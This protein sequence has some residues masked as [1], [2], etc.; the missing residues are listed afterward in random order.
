MYKC[1]IYIPDLGILGS[2][3]CTTI[4]V[5][6]VIL[7]FDT[8]DAMFS[9]LSDFKTKLGI[10]SRLLT[11]HLVTFIDYDNNFENVLKRRLHWLHWLHWSVPKSSQKI[12][13]NSCGFRI[14]KSKYLLII[15]RNCVNNKIYIV[16]YKQPISKFK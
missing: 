5:E 8:N 16:I 12:M 11:C 6:Y 15:S 4:I 14:T 1:K 9:A 3:F 7:N 13:A 10:Y 2:V